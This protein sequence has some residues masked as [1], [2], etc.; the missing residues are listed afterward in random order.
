MLLEFKTKNF[1]S[2][3]DECTL[4]MVASSDKT[5]AQTNLIQT[6]IKGLPS[7]VRAAAI[8]GA[9]ASGKSNVIRAIQVMR[10]IVL[11][12]AKYQLGQ[13][14]SMAQPFKLD[15]ISA[16]EPTEFEMTFLQK[17]VRYQYGFSLTPERII[18]EWLFAYPTAKA[19]KWFHREYDPTS[20]KDNY[21]FGSHLSGERR[22]WQTA[23][24]PNSLYL[25]TAVQLNS[26]QLKGI[27]EWFST[28]LVVLP[29]ETL[30][31]FFAETVSYIRAHANSKVKDFLINADMSIDNILIDN[32]KVP[33]GAF[34]ITYEDGDLTGKAEGEDIYMP[35]F[36]HITQNGSAAFELEDESGGT[37]RLF[38]LAGPLFD[39]L[40]NGYVLVVDE[41]NRGLHPLLVRQLVALFQNPASN[42]HG[43]QLLFTTHETNLLD[44]EF[45][46]RDQIWFTEKNADQVSTLFPLTE[47][48]PRKN[49]A[50]ESG[51]LSGRYGAVPILN[52]QKGIGID[53]GT[54]P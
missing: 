2:F 23:T 54:K 9:N 15:L 41:L 36:H 16:K 18:E 31:E 3:R 1:R 20:G 24:K 39:G 10:D 48:T 5:L 51:Y 21:F 17:G 53:S 12:S 44:P 33:K 27:F 38:S 47:F 26:E 46:R 52:P 25:S 8:Y 14:I 50:F 11:G 22:L 40:E 34:V 43:A 29:D 49:E 30:I 6:G 42:A 32:R 4:S 45:L 35:M 19:Q 7:V 37:Q 13:R 28:D